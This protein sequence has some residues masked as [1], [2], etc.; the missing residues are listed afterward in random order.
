[1]TSITFGFLN[2]PHEK[3]QIRYS[4]T[5]LLFVVSHQLLTVFNYPL[6]AIDLSLVLV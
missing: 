3:N 1:M 5:D 2:Y 6:L 4:Q